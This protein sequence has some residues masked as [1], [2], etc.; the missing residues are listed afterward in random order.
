MLWTVILANVGA[1]GLGL[2]AGQ[3]TQTFEP[4]HLLDVWMFIDK[5]KKQ[6]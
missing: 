5:G 1:A 2:I 6:K 4:S 3:V